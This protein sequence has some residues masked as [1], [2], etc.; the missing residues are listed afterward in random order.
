MCIRDRKRAVKWINNE[1]YCRYSVKEY[2]SKLKALNILPIDYKFLLNDLIMFHKIFYNMSVVQ[3]PG[4]LV[5]QDRTNT[6]VTYFQRQTRTFNNSDR[7]KLKCTITPRVNA[8]KNSFFYRSHLEWN[9]LPLDLRLIEKSE[10]FKS[11]L[12]KHLWQVA[13][14]KIN[15]T[16]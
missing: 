12:E 1:T 11:R 5:T 13:E 6:D 16:S 8:F 10:L 9:M 3:L 7:L 2:F 14:S 15:G 4:Y